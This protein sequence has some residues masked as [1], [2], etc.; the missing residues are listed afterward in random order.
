VFT[1]FLGNSIGSIVLLVVVFESFKISNRFFNSDAFSKKLEEWL[2]FESK[3][4]GASLLASIGYLA[5]VYL[6]AW[7]HPTSEEIQVFEIFH[8]AMVVAFMGVHGVLLFSHFKFVKNPLSQKIEVAG[9]LGEMPIAVHDIVYFEKIDRNYYVYSANQ[10]YRI[11]YTLTEIEKMLDNTHFFRINR[12]VIVH[13]AAIES[14]AR[15]EN[16]KYI[17]ILKN[18]KE[19]VVTRKRIVALKALLTK[20]K[21]PL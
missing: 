10:S 11:H 6:V 17:V 7:W 21:M 1:K 8:K 20:L 9:P 14:Y 3:L 18:K 12:A 2:L 5:I 13:I 4:I 16:D 15:W 19:L